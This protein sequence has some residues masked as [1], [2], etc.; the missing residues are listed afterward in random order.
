[1]TPLVF[2]DRYEVIEEIGSG[3]MGMVY[4]VRDRRLQR[5]LA[6]KTIRSSRTLSETVISRFI[7]EAQISS[8]LEHH[9]IVPIHDIGRLPDGRMFYTMAWVRG[10]TLSQWKR[11]NRFTTRANLH[12]KLSI[13]LK[14]CDAVAHAHRRSVIHRDL[15]P[16][17]VMIDS[18]NN[19]FV[20]DWGLARVID[21][22]PENMAEPSRS[23]SD[24]KSLTRIQTI[25]RADETITNPTTPSDSRPGNASSSSTRPGSVIGT[26]TYM[27]PE[28][29]KGHVDQITARSDV[30][31]LGAMLCELVTGHPPYVSN[32]PDTKLAMAICGDLDACFDRLSRCRAPGPIKTLIRQCLSVDQVQRPMNAAALCKPIEAFQQRTTRRQRVFH[33]FVLGGVVCAFVGTT[34]LFSNRLRKQSSIGQDLEIQRPKSTERTDQ[35]WN[36][37]ADDRLFNQI[38]NRKSSRGKSILSYDE[39]LKRRGISFGA[40]TDQIYKRLAA[41]PTKIAPIAIA[42]IL[43]WQSLPLPSVDSRRP[44][45]QMVD[46]AMRQLPNDAA[47]KIWQTIADC[48][49][50]A[51]ANQL[52]HPSQPLNEETVLAGIDALISRPASYEF[53][54][55]HRTRWRPCRIDSVKRMHPEKATVEKNGWISFPKID[56]FFDTAT[57]QFTSPVGNTKMVKLEFSA[58]PNTP[59]SITDIVEISL[60]PNVYRSRPIRPMRLIKIASTV[61]SPPGFGAY[62]AIDG[63]KSTLWRITHNDPDDITS[64]ILL[65]NSDTNA[66][67]MKGGQL[68]IQSGDLDFLNHSVLRRLKVSVASG[69]PEYRLDIQESLVTIIQRFASLHHR[70]P[71]ILA[72]LALRIAELSPPDFNAAVTLASNAVILDREGDRDPDRAMSVLVNLMLTLGLSPNDQAMLQLIGQINDLK[73]MEKRDHYRQQIADDWN[74]RSEAFR[75]AGIRRRADEYAAAVSLLGL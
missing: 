39:I 73:S 15:K 48:D 11:Q 24:A 37:L 26:V 35:Q 13:F 47:R 4:R 44:T 61:Y 63:N 66:S 52:L 25:R 53:D 19:V 60:E 65:I 18:N 72:L 31:S 2:A 55:W 43:R 57:I 23:P 20:I 5:Q 68:T 56:A 49:Y 46:V 38:A 6:L 62:S 29:A 69:D 22:G 74:S 1:M 42:S 36:D 71:R 12:A 17:N 32:D 67:F 50:E 75:E 33:G 51:L 40:S 9:G 70:R 58:P 21:A 59:S 28:Q 30:F 34:A 10:R 54:Q 27:P 7:E 14:V 45:P 16:S 8:Q 3:G 41:M 64:T